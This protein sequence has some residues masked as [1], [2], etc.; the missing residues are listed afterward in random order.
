MNLT[1]SW[2]DTKLL[3]QSYSKHM[4]TMDYLGSL[5]SSR[6]LQTTFVISLCLILQMWKNSFL[7]FQ[8]EGTKPTLSDKLTKAARA[9]GN[10]S[11]R[12]VP[13]RQ[14]GG[15]VMAKARTSSE[16]GSCIHASP[17][18]LIRYWHSAWW[19]KEMGT[20]T[21]PSTLI[22]QPRRCHCQ[23]LTPQQDRKSSWMQRRPWHHITCNSLKRLCLPIME[24]YEMVRQCHQRKQDEELELKQKASLAALSLVLCL[25]PSMVLQCH[26][27]K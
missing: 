23:L 26:T 2:L 11:R 12:Q 25:Q 6:S 9:T 7:K 18:V 17:N 13:A 19:A 3:Q 22:H 27:R 10:D 16:S 14:D 21:P 8:N 5:D 4:L 15:S 1:K 24:D 20:R